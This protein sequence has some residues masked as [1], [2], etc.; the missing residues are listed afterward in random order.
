[1]QKDV[2]VR[3]TGF[4]SIDGDTDPI[5]LV[6][7]GSFYEKNGKYFIVYDELVE[8]ESDPIRCTIKVNADGRHAEIG[9]GASGRLEFESGRPTVCCYS[10]PYGPL[11]LNIFASRVDFRLTEEEFRLEIDYSL[12]INGN[13]ATN[14]QASII[15]TPR[16]E[17]H[18]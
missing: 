15:A 5:S 9:R 17:N 18:P 7:P 6:A 1:M 10:T 13:P 4:H 14:V 11:Y 12:E 2:V 3:V 8:G 16:Q